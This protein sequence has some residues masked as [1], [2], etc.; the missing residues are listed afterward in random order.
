[1]T[2]CVSG[3][4]FPITQQIGKVTLTL[5]VSQDRSTGHRSYLPVDGTSVITCSGQLSLNCTH[6][7]Q[8]PILRE[9]A[10]DLVQAQGLAIACEFWPSI[11]VDLCPTTVMSKTISVLGDRD[12]P[13][14]RSDPRGEV[15][16]T[17]PPPIE[18]AI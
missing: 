4:Q 5:L 7:N 6:I 13:N 8:L 1:M 12:S 16:I 17:L 9:L 14:W 11:M 3:P 2:R 15:D 18:I 10:S